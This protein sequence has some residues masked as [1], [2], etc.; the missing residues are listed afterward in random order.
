MF[1]CFIVKLKT[2]KHYYQYN[3]CEIVGSSYPGNKIP[4][5][6]ELIERQNRKEWEIDIDVWN[7]KKSQ[8]EKKQMQRN[9]DLYR[10]ITYCFGKFNFKKFFHGTVTLG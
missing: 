3:K 4:H 7:G 2:G 10:S 1:I 9:K 8:Q 6:G 5:M